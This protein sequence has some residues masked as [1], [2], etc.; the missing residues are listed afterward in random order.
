MQKAMD[1]RPPAMTGWQS[2]EAAAAGLTLPATAIKQPPSAR[3]KPLPVHPKAP[4]VTRQSARLPQTTT[5]DTA[6]RYVQT[7]SSLERGSSG[8][9]SSVQGSRPARAAKRLRHTARPCSL[10]GGANKR[11]LGI[12][13]C[14]S[15]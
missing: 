1:L 8:C 15:G 3:S 4:S 11:L 12:L 10:Q 5:E 7:H 14:C 13:D 6:G 9:S 2:R